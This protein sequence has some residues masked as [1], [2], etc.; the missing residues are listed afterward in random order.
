[1][2]RSPR[3]RAARRRGPGGLLALLLAG[4]TLTGC[5]DYRLAP[6]TEVLTQV[7]FPYDEAFTKAEHE[8]PDSEPYSMS[9]RG[10]DEPVPVWYGRVATSDG[11][12]HEVRMDA[13]QGRVLGEEVPAGQ[14][15]AAKSRVAGLLAH[16]E[17][18]PSEA[19]EKIKEPYFGK[20][21][22]IELTDGKDDATVWRITVAEIHQ[23]DL[24]TYQVDAVTG[25]VL[26]SEKGGPAATP[27]V[28]PPSTPLPTLPPV[29][30]PELPTAP[31]STPAPDRPSP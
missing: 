6:P 22:Q 11:T 14:S 10:A 7:E 17:L 25:E 21:T 30:P 8:V 24:S 29:S 12:V 23:D 20:V 15:A 2:Q 27:T 13:T 3:P 4:V 26:T 31:P 9:L 28:A 1:M 16:A 5:T 19:V 18:L